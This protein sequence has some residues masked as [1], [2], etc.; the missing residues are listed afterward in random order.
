MDNID[1][2]NYIE[3]INQDEDDDR[4][5]D[6]YNK[7]KDV[8]ILELEQAL[9]SAKQGSKKFNELRNLL[10]ERNMLQARIENEYY[11]NGCKELVESLVKKIRNDIKEE[12]KEDKKTFPRMTF[13]SSSSS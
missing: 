7:Y 2:F 11:N 5:I 8:P 1:R 6:Y 9:V 3:Y 12:I 10:R 13:Y 4:A